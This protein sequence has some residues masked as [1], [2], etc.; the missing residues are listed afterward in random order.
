ME[1]LPKW[2]D[3]EEQQESSLTVEVGNIYWSHPLY[4]SRNET[5][6]SAVQSVSDTSI[7]MQ[8]STIKS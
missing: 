4:R 5:V 2:G 3:A 1:T 6:T 8:H 7:K